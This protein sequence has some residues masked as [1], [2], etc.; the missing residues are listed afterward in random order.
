MAQKSYKIFQHEHQGYE[1]VKIGFSWPG[2][3]FSFWWAFLKS[4]WAIVGL[5][6]L[7]LAVEIFIIQGLDHGD[8][9][10]AINLFAIIG[11]VPRFLIAW[12]GNRLRES[13]L[14]RAGYQLVATV[15][16]PSATKAFNAYRDQ[17]IK[18]PATPSQLTTH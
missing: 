4:L 6:I 3:F 15:T 1:T 13:Q 16:A 18:E 14:K 2:F 17:N 9:R 12:Y 10:D 5:A 11:V 7:Y 8:Q